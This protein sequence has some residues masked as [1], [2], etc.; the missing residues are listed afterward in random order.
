MTLT[1]SS[2]SAGTLARNYG[3]TNS[4]HT[5]KC[6]LLLSLKKILNFQTYKRSWKEEKSAH[7]SWRAQKRRMTVLA[8]ATRNLLDCTDVEAVGLVCP[9]HPS[10][11]SMCYT[12]QTPRYNCNNF[13]WCNGFNW[14]EMKGTGFAE[15]HFCS[16]AKCWGVM[17][18]TLGE[19]LGV[20][21]GWNRA[22]TD[23][24]LRN[25]EH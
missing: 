1:G 18:H 2:V 25:L 23:I 19:W 17:A 7:G 14:L 13:N 8:R 9:P 10:S 6:Q 16:W 24:S 11:A 21:A 5:Q 20:G 22:E 3:A 12:K 4:V 15:C